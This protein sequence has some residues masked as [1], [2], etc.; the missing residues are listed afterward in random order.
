[1]LTEGQFYT[2]Q[3]I[4]D[5]LGGGSLQSYLPTRDGVVL[6]ACLRRDTN[7]DAPRVILPGTGPGIEEAARLLRRQGGAIPVFIKHEAGAW[8][9]LGEYVVEDR[10]WTAEDISFHE[11]RSRRTDITSVI[12]M[13][14]NREDREPESS[15]HAPG[16]P[17]TRYVR[18]PASSSSRR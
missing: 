16:S 12:W 11:R 1:M 14:A 17:A 10:R 4:H 5:L 15:S 13:R 6:C 2:R 3:E 18:R 7:P 9:Y 8:E